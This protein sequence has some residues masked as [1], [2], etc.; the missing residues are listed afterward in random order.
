M[1]KI[2][3]GLKN[4]LY[5]CRRK[6]EGVSRCFN[7]VFQILTNPQYF[8]NVLTHNII[9]K[10]TSIRGRSVVNRYLSCKCMAMTMPVKA[11]S[12]GYGSEQR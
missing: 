4:Y 12:L 1:Q 8:K 3:G 9:M 6:I 7:L 2:F 5:L 10:Y 11:I